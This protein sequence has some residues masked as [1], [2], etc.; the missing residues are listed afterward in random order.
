MN[1]II[2]HFKLFIL[3]ILVCWL[4][5]ISIVL[6]YENE[7]LRVELEKLEKNLKASRELRSTEKDSFATE[8]TFAAKNVEYGANIVKQ[9][10]QKQKPYINQKDGYDHTAL[11]YIFKRINESR[12]WA[13]QLLEYSS[14]TFDF[15]SFEYVLDNKMDNEPAGS[16]PTWY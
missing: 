16:Y 15:E 6:P 9:I 13:N 5:Q 11:Y 2:N 4:F 3:I 14:K 8:L 12:Y 10:L 7:F 1:F